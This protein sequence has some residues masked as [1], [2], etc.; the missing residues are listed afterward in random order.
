MI[1]EIEDDGLGFD[2]QELLKVHEGMRGIGLLGMRERVSLVGGQLTLD[3]KPDG[4]TRI[5][6]EVP[7]TA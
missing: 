5:Q 6:I 2:P 7:W 3:S 4:G 1:A